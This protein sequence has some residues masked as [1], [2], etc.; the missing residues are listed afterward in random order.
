MVWV[1]EGHFGRHMPF[2][3][4]T[5][6]LGS[7]KTSLLND[8]LRDPRL[9]DTAVA[10]NEFGAI[11]LDHIFVE[12][13]A[14]DVIVLAN[15]CMCCFAGDDLEA[16]LARIFRRSEA[17]DL[18]PF[19]RL[20]IE[21][22]GLAD[23]EYVLQA[24]L[25]SP[26]ASRFLWLDRIVTTVDALHG[27]RQLAEHPE[28]RKQARLADTIVITKTDLAGAADLAAVQAQLASLNGEARQVSRQHTGFGI[29]RLFSPLFLDEDEDASLLGEWVRKEAPL[30]GAFGARPAVA[31]GKGDAAH[32]HDHR[33]ADDATHAVAIVL[34][35][36]TPVAWRPF[37][38]WLGREQRRLGDRL[39]RVKGMVNVAGSP[40]P[41]VVHGV[42]STAH[43]PVSLRQWPDADRRTRIVFIL[44]EDDEA[45]LRRSWA[46]FLNEEM[47]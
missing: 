30:S 8:L 25:D 1:P 6:F 17:G 39:L 12:A 33:H 34:T 3:L 23:P 26:I 16:S 9:R 42:Q 11:P 28:A 14:D 44:T 10:I 47:V 22:S 31:T 7:G 20:I 36:D 45:E 24:V 2:A 43:V 27:A 41:V 19:K 5:G 40:E 18:P 46:T 32:R 38:L 29:D 21:T 35:A 13:P 37:D 4:L 15:G